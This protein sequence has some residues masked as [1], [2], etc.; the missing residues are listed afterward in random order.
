MD[1][2]I[3]LL[4]GQ[5]GI[6]NGAIYALLALALVL[7]FAVTRVIFIPQGE[8]VAFGALTLVSL[9][10][11]RLPGTIWLLLALGTVIVLIDGSI[12][13][14]DRQFRR[15]PM[16]LLLNCGVPLMLGGALLALSP[17]G[18]PLPVQVVLA[19]MLVVPLG[20]MIYR[21]AYQP[22]AGASVLALL[23]VSVA[24]H[25]TLIGIGLLFFGAEGS[26]TL[27][28]TDISFEVGDALLQG[29]T[30]LVVVASLVLIV[31]LY[32]FFER[33]IYGKALRATAMNRTGA[34]LMGIS[35]TLAGMLS[36]TLAAAIGAFSGILISP[37][38]TIYYDSGFLIGLKG[39]VGAIIGGLASYPVAAAGAVLVGLLES[40]SSFWASA[41]KEVIVFTS[42][43]PVLVWRSLKTRHVEEE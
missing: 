21:L 38:T 31:A 42:I 17:A 15:L 39:F 27:A 7:V 40:Y 20:P 28:F 26:R 25:V 35:G 13:L 16:I 6:T 10:T 34:R 14:R 30:I 43:I 29:Q 1:L 5:D 18:L 22:I 12:A 37:I 4:L 33:T 9:Q 2:Q 23:I 3:A 41:F 19:L 32:F 24:V 8:F 36:F 11:G